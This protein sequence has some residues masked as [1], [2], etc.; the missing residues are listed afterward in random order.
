MKRVS[1]AFVTRAAEGLQTGWVTVPQ[2]RT[3]GGRGAAHQEG[4]D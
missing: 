1:L 3:D 4:A 2:A